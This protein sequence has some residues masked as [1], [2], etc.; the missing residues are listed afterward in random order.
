MDVFF[1][2]HQG[3]PQ[4]A[5]GSEDSTRRALSL[6]SSLPAGP[7]ILDVGCGPGRQTLILARETDGVV[8]AVDN[9]QPYLDELQTR[10][11]EQGFDERIAAQCCSMEDM[12]FDDASFDLIWAEGSIYIIG[13]QKGLT[14][15]RRFLRPQGH[16]AVT[17][18]TWLVDSGPEEATRFFGEAYPA[19]QN[20]AG[21]RQTIQQSGYS[22]IDT[23]T[24]PESAWWDGY[25]GPMEKRISELREKYSKDPAIVET[26]DAEQKEIDLYRRYSDTYGYVFYVMRKDP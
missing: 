24:L 9:H 7:S 19:M 5:P 10:A 14:S 23:F 2:I 18:L 22:L 16:M 11:S 13:F 4:E 3:L 12:G 8:T 21:N 25:Y 6:V 1:E 26:L 20:L 17:E 15:W